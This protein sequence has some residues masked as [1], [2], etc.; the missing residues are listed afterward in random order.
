MVRNKWVMILAGALLLQVLLVAVSGWQTNALVARPANE[1]LLNFETAQID[2]IVVKDAEGNSAELRKAA[3]QWQLPTLE[4]AQA[5]AA[6][7]TAVLD[8]LHGLKRGLPV[9]TSGADFK[10]FKVDDSGFERQVQLLQGDTVKATL[11]LGNGAGASRSY[12]RLPDDKVVYSTS[13]GTYELPG[14]AESWKKPEPPPPP[15]AEEQAGDKPVEAS[16]PPPSA[17]PP[18]GAPPQ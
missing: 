6:K 9:A 1:A 14:K 16:P 17:T 8:K 11:L 3:D 4:N 18:A 13:I 15:K 2:H 5:D 10:R 12:A 7:I